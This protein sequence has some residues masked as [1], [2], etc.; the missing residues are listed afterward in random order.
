MTHAHNFRNLTGHHFGRITVLGFSHIDDNGNS[1]WKCRC[2]CGTVFVTS[3]TA[4]TR[5]ATRSCGCI[6]SEHA[7]GNCIAM[8]KITR[9]ITHITD[10]EGVTHIFAS[11]HEAAKWLRVSVSLISCHARTGQPYNGYAIARGSYYRGADKL[12]TPAL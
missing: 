12:N 4:L 1:A 3:G 5:G 2:E 11:M 10:P 6:R 7:R 8:H 9:V